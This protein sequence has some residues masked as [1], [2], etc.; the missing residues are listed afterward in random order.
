MITT[1]HGLTNSEVTRRQQQYG[2]NIL[3][4]KP[5][6]SKLSILISQL[7]SPLVFILLIASF[8]TVTIGHYTDA[9]IIFFAVSINT[10]LGFVQEYRAS[11]ALRALKH[12][13][14]DKTIVI[15]EGVKLS[16]DASQIVVGDIIVLDQG[17]KI[18][19]DGK[20][21]TANRLY[22]DEAVLTGESVPVT[23]T[24]EDIV[25]MGT[26]ISSGQ[27]TMVVES[28]GAMTKMGAIASEIQEKEE[29]TP[30]QKQLKVF[31]EDVFGLQPL[32]AGSDDK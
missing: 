29:D 8:I 19:A 5:A 12:Y 9:I 14:T 27:A 28:I 16:V 17:S 20:L 2:Q 3:P 7:K 30:L 26:T 18:P 22:I 4:E 25:F 6:P 21:Q 13:I 15:R 24:K 10:V 23:K 11:N 1:V 32:S 31:I